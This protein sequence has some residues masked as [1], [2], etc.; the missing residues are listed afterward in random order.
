MPA[1][2]EKAVQDKYFYTDDYFSGTSEKSNVHLRSMSMA[3]ALS[4]M[5]AG[6]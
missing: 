5:E 1:L 2:E 6:G 4:T 3:L